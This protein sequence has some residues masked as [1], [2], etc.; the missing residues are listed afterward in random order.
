MYIDV[1]SS[2]ERLLVAFEI[3]PNETIW[4]RLTGWLANSLYQLILASLV[5][6]V[7][8]EHYSLIISLALHR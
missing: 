3:A 6:G 8:L 7:I 5:A 4:I 1:Y 2:K